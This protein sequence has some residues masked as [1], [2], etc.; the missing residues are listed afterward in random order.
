M[1]ECTSSRMARH[2]WIYPPSSES[3][4]REPYRVF[5][6]FDDLAYSDLPASPIILDQRVGNDELSA[7]DRVLNPLV[8]L[9]FG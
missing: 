7:A 2:V 5:L 6:L 8:H 1:P 4:K 9:S 3:K